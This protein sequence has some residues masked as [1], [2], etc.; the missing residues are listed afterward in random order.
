MKNLKEL[1]SA[2]PVIKHNFARRIGQMVFFDLLI[3]LFL[4][5][6]AGSLDWRIAWF[7]TVCMVLIQL[8]GAFILPLEIIAERGSKKTYQENWDKIITR[9]IL[10]FF[11]G[12]YLVSGFDFR[13]QWSPGYSLAWHLVAVFIFSMGGLL[14]LWAMRT[15][16]FFSTTVRIQFDRGQ[17]VC[18]NGPYKYV[19]HPGYLG[20]ILYYA[21]TPIFLG[22]L[23]ALIPAAMVVVLLVVRTKLED[24]TLQDKL[25][26]YKEY[27]DRVRFRLFPGIW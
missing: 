25:S 13:W 22:S 3:A 6:C 4:F 18:S 26:G 17:V 8:F 5:S 21:V 12:I 14:E 20:F 19:R 27:A 1:A 7:Y 10:P 11:F 24:R 2:S 9:L 15:N 16:R 23:W